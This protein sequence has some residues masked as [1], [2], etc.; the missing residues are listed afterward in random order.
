M[1]AAIFPNVYCLVYYVNLALERS[2][3][4]SSRTSDPKPPR[5]PDV[6]ALYPMLTWP[7]LRTSARAMSA[8]RRA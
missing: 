6:F 2:Q 7:T 4:M 3:T 1:S 8:S 5:A